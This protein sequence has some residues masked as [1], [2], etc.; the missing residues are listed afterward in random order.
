MK[1]NPLSRNSSV[2]DH[3]QSIFKISSQTLITTCKRHQPE[4]RKL[5]QISGNLIIP[6]LVKL[7][8]AGHIVGLW[9]GAVKQEG[10][11]GNLSIFPI[12]RVQ[13]LPH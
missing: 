4:T 3:V 12:C 10:F 8:N 5:R 1:H 13:T 7:I 2:S 9:E 11:G 6:Q